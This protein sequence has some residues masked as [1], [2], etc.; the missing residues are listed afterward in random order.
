MPQ[1]SE[2][3]HVKRR[4]LQGACDNCRKRKIRCNSAET[5]GQRCTNCVTFKT[6]CTHTRSKGPGSEKSNPNIWKVAQEHVA[7]I[8]STST[9]Y[10]P[11][12]DPNVS[13]QVLVDVAKYARNLEDTID[14]LRREMRSAASSS[15][16]K[17]SAPK[18]CGSPADLDEPL[19]NLFQSSPKKAFRNFGRCISNQFLKTALK[20]F[21]GNSLSLMVVQR[22]EFWDP[23]PWQ[24][25]I[26]IETPRQF[27]PEN[28]LLNA[29]VDIYF[30][31]IN[32]FLG[33]LHS[34]SFRQSI[35]DG[36]HLSHPHFGAVVL[37]VCALASRYSDDPRGVLDGA[38]SEHSRGWKWFR[39]VHSLCAT[40]SPEHSLYQL[41]LIC[42]SITY[43]PCTGI[44]APRQCWILAGLG[45]R[46]AHAAGAHRR[47]GYARMDPLTAELYKRAFWVLVVSDTIMSSLNGKSSI[48]QPAD[49][50]LDL[51][52]D[53]DDEYWGIANPVQPHGKPSI[54]AFFV[55]Y[56]QL[57]MIFRRIQEAVYP[58]NGQVYSQ[59]VVVELDSALN[60]WVD[61][62]PNH[63]RWDPHQQNQTFLNQSAALY[64]TYYHA[65]ILIHRPFIPTPG[66]QSISN[67]NFPSLAIC[68]N[69][70]RSCGHVLNL[71][72]RRGRLLHLPHVV[73]CLF[74]CAVVLL[75]N[76]WAIGGDQ[77]A[78]IAENFNRATT[79]VQTCARVLRLYERRWRLAG[80]KYDI[81]SAMLNVGNDLASLKRSS[82]VEVDALSPSVSQVAVKSPGENVAGPSS[83][84]QTHE[85]DCSTDHLFSL[86]LHTDELGR[87]PI[88]DPFHYEFTFHYQQDSLNYDAASGLQPELSNADLLTDSVF[89]T[90]E[91]LFGFRNGEEM[92]VF[93]NDLSGNGWQDLEE[94]FASAGGL[95]QET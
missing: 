41:Q 60:N 59:D 27:F 31:E 58:V 53:C 9:I 77:K 75:V 25:L 1:E 95:N 3:K 54:S 87:L 74:D 49:F 23:Q 80:R 13:H 45:L 79:D 86:P 12:N 26:T 16:W 51:P 46:F 7:E 85:L 65:Q 29:L 78:R 84:L 8:L 57:M 71:Q 56:L 73:I 14:R 34:P 44:P 55:V 48:T 11:S 28:D 69:A 88:Y 32:P 40:F 68:A 37:A 39:Q 5:P 42:L 36:L 67:A 61:G 62:I 10:V 90:Q 50:D 64:S 20:H 94:Y 82:N 24:K 6:A 76:V 2:E 66:K 89:Y 52:L 72:A 43:L 83:D 17:S 38:T 47:S 33:I 15:E 70:A 63:L 22:P 30:E 81:I 4:R 19:D 35:S 93:S 91:D 92:Q 21:H 18:I